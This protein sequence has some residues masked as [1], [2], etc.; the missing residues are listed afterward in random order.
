MYADFFEPPPRE[1]KGPKSKE[2]NGGK[3][4]K[5]KGKLVSSD[6]EEPASAP[7]KVDAKGKGKGKATLDDSSSTTPVKAKGLDADGKRSVRFSSAVK[8]KT[9][10][11]RG[12]AFDKLVAQVGWERASE[13]IDAAEEVEAEAGVGEES[14]LEDAEGVNEDEEE[15]EDDEEEDEDEDVDMEDAEEQDEEEEEGSE[16]Y[17]SEDEEGRETIDRLKSSLFDEDE[18]EEVEGLTPG[19]FSCLTPPRLPTLLI[20]CRYVLFPPAA[21]LSRHER[22]LLALSS[23]IAALEAENVGAKDWATKGEAKAKDRPVNSLLEEDLE[24]ERAG[25][26]VPVITEET[27]K[28]IEDLIK[29]RILDVSS[30]LDFWESQDTDFLSIGH[31]INSTM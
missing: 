26:V 20:P 16:E 13:I 2:T 17:E 3:R 12:S 29:K 30:M 4:N 7:K 1:F 10:A 27:T 8:V 14:I 28:T 9:I 19:M 5:G 22:R 24:Y 21:S 6:D 31:R 11:A 15:D 23:Q 25:K 18:P